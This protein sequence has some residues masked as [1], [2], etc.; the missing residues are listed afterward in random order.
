[1]TALSDMRSLKKLDDELAMTNRLRTE[2]TRHLIAAAL[3]AGVQKLVVQ[4]YGGWSNQ[5]VGG[6]VKTE[7][8]P[9]DANPPFPM[10]RTL[11]AIKTLEHTVLNAPGLN[12]VALRYASLYG[13]GTSI[14]STGYVVELVRGRKFP[15][16]GDGAGVWSF[17]HVDDAARATALAIEH[18]AP[19]VY[20]VCDDEPAEVSTWL[21]E[22]AE[23]LGA[24]PPFHVPA[25][26][27]RFAIGEAG[28]SMMT[29]IRGSS[30]VKAKRALGWQLEYP[31]W[32][33]GFRRG[34]GASSGHNVLAKAV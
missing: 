22:L 15:L 11:A 5:R 17:I 19:G 30:N 32:R 12:G 4:S 9:L 10:S 34:L 20:N 26:I 21:P 27:G 16:V 29:K 14:S 2:G 6:R 31:S 18:G 3:A 7:A 33:D 1:M 24:R 25:W 23:V 8:D 28:V 13:P